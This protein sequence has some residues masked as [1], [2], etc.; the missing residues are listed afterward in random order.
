MKKINI[1]LLML[2]P[3]FIISAYLD[4]IVEPAYAAAVSQTASVTNNNDEE[5]SSFDGSQTSY[6]TLNG[7]SITLKGSGA[8][9]DGR[10]VTI[11]STGKYNISGTLGN[12]Q[13]IVNT[14][15][16]EKVELVLNGVNITCSESAPL[17]II[18]AEKTV[19]T[20]ADLTE[21]YITD[22]NSYADDNAES[23][24]PNAAIFSND[25]LTI[26]GDGLLTVNANYRNGIQSRDDLK[27]T[28]GNI[29]VNAENDGIKGRD[30]VSIEGGKIQV[31][32]GGDGIQSD[33]D[34][35]NDVDTQEGHVSIEGGTIDITAGNDGIKGKDS[36]S[37]REANIQVKAGGDGIQSDNDIDTEKGNV[38]IESGT[39]D[40]TA[41]NDGIQAKTNVIISGGAITISSGGGSG[42]SSNYSSRRDFGN[43][44]YSS[45]ASISTKGIKAGV[46]L[47][48]EGGTIHVDSSDD[49]LHS[50]N[51]LT[52]NGGKTI[53][54]SGDDGIHSNSTIEINGGNINITKSYEGI[55]STVITINDGDISI[56]ANDDGLNATYISQMNV[57][58]IVNGGN[59]DVSVASGDT[60]AFDSNGSLFINGGTI[61]V[62]ARSAFD[63]SGQASLL[64]GDVTVNGQVITEIRAERMGGGMR[65][66]MGG[67]G[68]R[69]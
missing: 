17:Y 20:L 42:N 12:G 37:I 23:N 50:G 46:D 54:A 36:V 19:I 33:K 30:S 49:S 47:T 28:G 7:N 69:R 62:E 53:L 58:I 26:K 63:A 22:S 48:I 31:K 45:T 1:L 38:S 66:G 40:I 27:I 65:G 13:I 68:R 57:A 10:I 29:F 2:I 14:Q 34:S 18:N 24:E 4:D 41:G 25:D 56:F 51:S 61:N 32:A 8:I 64:G 52:I 55:E 6:V 5:D 16:D 39:I 59:I 60:D 35:D 43:R 21:N 44:R 15:D 9:V 67:R 11:T 3:I